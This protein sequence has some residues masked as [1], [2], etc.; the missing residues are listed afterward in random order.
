MTDTVASDVA[1][2]DESSNETPSFDN[3]DV[4]AYVDS[5]ENYL[6]PYAAAVKSKDMT[7]NG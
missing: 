1:T 4:Q 5:Y 7:K 6:E 2:T 3:A